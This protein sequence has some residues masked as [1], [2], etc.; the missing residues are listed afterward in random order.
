MQS[1]RYIREKLL[2]AGATT[3]VDLGCGQGRVLEAL[4]GPGRPPS[5]I[6]AYGMDV[7]ES[8]THSACKRLTKVCIYCSQLSNVVQ[9]EASQSFDLSHN[10]PWPCK[11]RTA[12]GVS[13][14]RAQATHDCLQPL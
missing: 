5:L 7:S 9:C 1:L 13:P 12:L 4:V 14:Q 10:P 6:A 2:A 3:V 11:A 8:A